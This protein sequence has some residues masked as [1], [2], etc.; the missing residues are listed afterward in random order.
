MLCYILQFKAIF[1]DGSLTKTIKVSLQAQPVSHEIVTKLHG[2]RVAVSPIVTVEPRR[3]KFHKPITLCIPLPST[4]HKGMLT[5]YAN[6]QQGQEPPTL[7]LL[8]SITGFYQKIFFL[9]LFDL[10]RWLFTCSM[11]RHY[12]H[13]AVDFHRRG[14]FFHNY[15]ICQILADGLPNT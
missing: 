15:R 1:P 7:R 11:G 14:C 3:R 12:W 5:Q 4:G 6:Q 2:N 13:N 9:V 10:Y 8:C